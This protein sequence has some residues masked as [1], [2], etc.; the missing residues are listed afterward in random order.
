[1]MFWH[2]IRITECYFNRLVCIIRALGSLGAR[3]FPSVLSYVS[4]ILFLHVRYKRSN[5]LGF[6]FVLFAV[7]QSRN[8]FC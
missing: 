5:A 1:M 6:L 3:I 7:L 4:S 2:F 8:R